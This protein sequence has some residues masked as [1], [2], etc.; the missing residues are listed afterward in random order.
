MRLIKPDISY[1]YFEDFLNQLNLI[2]F[3]HMFIFVTYQ[4]LWIH[5]LMGRIIG[6]DHSLGRKDLLKFVY[7]FMILF[8]IY[9]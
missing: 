7:Y 9:L 6:Y 3:L 5:E 2:Y 8:L 4:E 1:I